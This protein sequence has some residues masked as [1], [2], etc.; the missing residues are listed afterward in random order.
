MDMD[1]TDYLLRDSYMT[2]V[3]YG[4]IDLEWLIHSLRVGFWGDEAELGLAGLERT[5]RGPRRA[6]PQPA[7]H[8]RATE[9]SCAA[10]EIAAAE[11]AVRRRR[12]S[13]C[14]VLHDRLLEMNPETARRPSA[15]LRMC[16]GQMDAVVLC[17]V[18]VPRGECRAVLGSASSPLTQESCQFRQ[19]PNLDCNQFLADGVQEMQDTRPAP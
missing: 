17:A 1:R 16:E 7:H 9:R 19:D 18:R 11:F 14:L 12:K 3:Q 13:Q 4:R 5:A 15:T 6:G 8:R 2:G 10:N